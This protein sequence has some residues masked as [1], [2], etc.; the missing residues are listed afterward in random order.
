MHD[1]PPAA[2]Q[3]AAAPAATTVPVVIPKEDIDT[4]GQDLIDAV[5]RWV[6]P[7]FEARLTELESKFGQQVKQVETGHQ[8]LHQQTVKE[9]VMGTLDADREIGSIWREVNVDHQFLAWLNQE[10]PFYGVPRM[11]A[12]QDAFARGDAVRCKRFFTTYIAEHTA[13]H[14]PVPIPAE[15]APTEQADRPTLET[16]AAPGRPTGSAS[17]NSGAPEKRFWT[18]PQIAAFYRDVQ[19]GVYANREA[20]KLRIEMDIIAAPQEGRVR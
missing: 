9:R 15:T 8:Q 2:P 12:L 13:T 19:K 3:P 7:R 14:T 16:M 5:N 11:Q 6:M 10:D 20:E 17:N 1:T 18:R 4:Y